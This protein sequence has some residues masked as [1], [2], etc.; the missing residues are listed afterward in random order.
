MF[1]L[2]LYAVT[3]QLVCRIVQGLSAGLSIDTS[4]LA[5]E[6]DALKLWHARLFADNP[7]C[8]L[9]ILFVTIISKTNHF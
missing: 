2:L 5:G 4:V 8:S 9:Y 3:L 7:V 6:K 1:T